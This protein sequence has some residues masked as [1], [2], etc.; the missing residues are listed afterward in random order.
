MRL[1]SDCIACLIERATYECDMVF[2][3]EEESKIAVL[4][5]ITCFVCSHL[6]REGITP[7]FF[8][9][10]R[11]RILKLR[12]GVTDPH[13]GVKRRSNEVAKALLPVAIE[14]FNTHNDSV[15]A[16]VRIAAAANSMEYG[17]K[18]YSYDDDAF[19]AEF[20][21]VLN[22][23]LNWNRDSVLSAIERYDKMIYLTDNAGEVFFDAFVVK[24]LAKMGKKV[25]IS[26][27]SDA[28]I[29][30]ATVSDWQEAAVYVDVPATVELV[31]AAAC[32]GVSREEASEEFLRVF[33]DDEYLV[34]AKGMGNYE[35]ISEFESEY[36]QRLIYILRA[37][38]MPVARS[39]GVKRGELVAKFV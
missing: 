6:D 26:P 28:I 15:E 8:G 23:R 5:E 10:E 25:V 2:E 18:G 14:Y 1:K 4:K 31:P 27:K 37:K 19:K 32:I 33:N 7:A 29:N 24:E 11:E 20:I 36:R 12:S 30:D 35:A 34:I 3:E 39:I 16:L 38:C 9:T 17:V 22:E 13:A 21:H